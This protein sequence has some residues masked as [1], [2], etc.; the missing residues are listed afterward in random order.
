[1]AGVGKI[2][3]AVDAAKG[4][5]VD[6]QTLKLPDEY[7]KAEDALKKYSV[8]GQVR[9]RSL[10]WAVRILIHNRSFNLV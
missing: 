7:T 2:V 8:L 10:S 3:G 6:I 9:V 5:K 1:M 4:I